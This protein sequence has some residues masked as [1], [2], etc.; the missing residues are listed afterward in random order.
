VEWNERVFGALLV[1][2]LIVLA[3]FYSWR[4]VSMLR[5]LRGP[6][7][8][9]DEEAHW[10]R[11]QAR[12]RLIGSALMLALAALLAWAV[13]V[14]GEHAQNLADQGPAGDTPESHHFVR[15]YTIVWIILL[16]LLLVLV[17]LAA[18]DIWFTRRFSL[19][20]Q[21]K[22]LAER[23]SM[24]EREVARLRERRNGDGE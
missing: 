9:S 3:G 17:I 19:R 16:L 5:R 12:R 14:V 10:R 7:G 8:L 24:L 11:G 15:L 6:H 13:L 4:Q 1:A 21:R 2:T 20:Q 23:R 22:I 18:V